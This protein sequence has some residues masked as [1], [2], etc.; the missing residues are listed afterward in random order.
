MQRLTQITLFLPAL[1][2]LLAFAFPDKSG[3]LFWLSVDQLTGSMV[4]YTSILSVL[5]LG[6]AHKNYEREERGKA[7]LFWFY[8]TV[9]SVQLLILADHVVLIFLGFLMISMGLH[10]LLLSFPTRERSQYAA[11]KKFALSRIGDA[12]FLVAI[13]FFY[14]IFQTYSLGEAMQIA[15]TW[16]A[17]E[18]LDKLF[19]PS[20]FLAIACLI[21]SAQFPFH[22]WLPETIDAPTPVSA[23]MHAGIINAGGFL[24]VKFRFLYQ[25]ESPVVWLVLGVGTLT[26]WVGGLSM[27]S[28]VDIK[29]KLAYSTLGQM[30]FMMVEFALGLYPLVILHLMGHG[31]YKA[32]GFLTSGNREF[33]PSLPMQAP[34]YKVAFGIIGL[35]V[36]TGLAIYFGNIEYGLVSLLGI[37]LLGFLPKESF[38]A[39][40]LIMLGLVGLAVA[41]PEIGEWMTGV[42]VNEEL[43]NATSSLL[44]LAQLSV[45][46][47][48][49]LALPALYKT[50]FFQSLYCLS[51]RGF[52]SGIISDKIIQRVQ[53]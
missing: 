25:A 36:P 50:S 34:I 23:I 16:E 8:L 46:G 48:F 43:L 26:L 42:A 28:Q 49:I 19:Y 52:M 35:L 24:L 7:W 13:Y 14:Q 21:K 12:S 44:G 22:F 3:L 30:G 51:Q 33:I 1:V 20:L 11:W 15:G 41:L 53:S 47:F 27:L 17:S 38:F 10:K 39:S 4:F 40:S 18:Q 29:R 45:L 31:F 5:I 32:H 9:F 37:L 6:Y 2:W